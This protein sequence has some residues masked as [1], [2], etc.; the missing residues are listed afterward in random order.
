MVKKC[1]VC[2]DGEFDY[3]MSEITKIRHT[4]PPEAEL[5]GICNKCGAYIHIEFKAYKAKVV[6]YDGLMEK[7]DQKFYQF[8][9]VSGGL[10]PDSHEKN[11]AER[12]RFIMGEEKPKKE[13][14]FCPP[15]ENP[16]W[17]D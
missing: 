3:S 11:K 10:V 9:L 6:E 1:T 8:E 5:E 17:F 16:D 13:H 15:G 7:K 4:N 14:S 12:H 2:E